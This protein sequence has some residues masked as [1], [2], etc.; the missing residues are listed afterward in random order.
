MYRTVAAALVLV[1][2]FSFSIAQTPGT[3]KF[4]VA[5]VKSS[6]IG[7]AGDESSRRESIEP[8][9]TG[10]TMRNVSLKS[11]IMWAYSIREYQLSAPQWLSDA[12]YDVL[13][14]AAG[15]VSV[16]QLR[17]M[18]QALLADRLG[19]GVRHETRQLSVYELRA[20]GKAPKLR[21]VPAGG[22]SEMRMTDGSMIFT[23]TSMVQLAEHL[24]IIMRRQ[25]G[26]PVIDET[27]LKGVFDFSLKF[28]D[29]NADLR[30]A[31]VQGDGGWISGILQEQLGL[32][33]T[34]GKAG[35]GV[36]I[37]DRAEKIPTDN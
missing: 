19:L 16:E 23:N 24:E 6:K 28:A 32:R 33:L 10:L 13:A 20:N 3:Q 35:V 34:G 8:S 27:G 5:S 29:T 25:V 2:C 18:L 37:V 31:M 4:E 14:K 36:V 9:S 22:D 1:S 26:L 12:R 7:D 11:C 30:A 21:E 17:G 15:P